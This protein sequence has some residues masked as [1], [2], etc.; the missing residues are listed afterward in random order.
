MFAAVMATG[1]VSIAAADHGYHVISDALAGAG[2][3]RACR[4]WWSWWRVAWRGFGLARSRRAAG[5]VH[6]CRGVCGAGGAAAPS[7][8][9]CCGCWPAWR[10]RAG[11]RW[12]R[13]RRARMWRLRWTALRDRA[14]GGWELASVATSGLAIVSAISTSSSGPCVF[15]L[16]A[17]CVY[18]LMTALILWRASPTRRARAVPARRV[19]PDGRGGDRDAGRRPPASRAVARAVRRWRARR[20]DR[21]VGGGHAVDSRSLVY[22]PVRRFAGVG[23]RRCSRWACTRRRRSRWPSKPVGI[24]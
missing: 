1:I 10:C 9:S 19:D 5:A 2:G 18:L 7:H 12:R 15:W 8:A 6:L 24:G 13:W 14:H 20:D 16:L 22:V 3:G 4:S 21:D 23:G 11:C 17:M